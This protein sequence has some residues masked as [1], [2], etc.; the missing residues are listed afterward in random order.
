[1]LPFS[2]P[3][4]IKHWFFG[5][6]KKDIILINAIKLELTCFNDETWEELEN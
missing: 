2:R 1:M 5:P 3:S 4:P 6:E